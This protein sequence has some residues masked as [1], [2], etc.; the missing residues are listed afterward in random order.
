[1]FILTGT[2]VTARI[3]NNLVKSHIQDQSLPFEGLSLYSPGVN[4]SIFTDLF[5]SMSLSVQH[6]NFQR[7]FLDLTRV[8]ARMDFPSGL[9]FFSGAT[10]LAQDIYNSRQ[11]STDAIRTICPKATFS[12]QQQVPTFMTPMYFLFG[13]SILLQ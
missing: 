3:G 4:S 6:G 1:M 8:Y 11:P 10:Q 2:F 7:L 13:I 9:R 5:G 12:V